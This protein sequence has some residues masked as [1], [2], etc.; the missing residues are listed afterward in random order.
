MDFWIA[1]DTGLPRLWVRYI[2]SSISTWFPS[3]SLPCFNIRFSRRFSLA[4]Q[5][6]S[7]DSR[8]PREGRDPDVVWQMVEES[9][10]H[11]H[12]NGERK[13]EQ[14]EFVGRRQYR[15]SLE[16]IFLQSFIILYIIILYIA[17]IWFLFDTRIQSFFFL[18]F[19]CRDP[20][21]TNLE[22][23]TSS[24]SEK[25]NKKKSCSRSGLMNFYIC[26]KINF[27]CCVLGGVFVVL[28][29]G[30]AFAVVIAIFEFCYNTRRSAPEQVSI[31]SKNHFLHRRQR[32]NP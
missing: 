4:W 30:L 12:E 2:S 31:S 7:G 20:L 13:G 14:S 24:T 25:S 1:K 28:L 19:V 17:W 29:C 26:L 32:F 21:H 10:W 8:T 11:L 3:I 9:R 16:N 22:R 27:F 6:I 15:W 5:D 18:C 23:R